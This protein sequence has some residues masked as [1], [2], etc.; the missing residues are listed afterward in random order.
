M[1]VVLY[2]LTLTLSLLAKS[3]SLTLSRSLLTDWIIRFSDTPEV[4]LILVSSAYI[5]G[6]ER[7]RE[8]GRS[9]TYR[10]KSR[11]PRIDPWGTPHVIFRGD[12]RCPC[13]QHNC[14][15]SVRYDLNHLQEG[16]PT[17][18][19]AS[20]FSNTLWSTVSN[21]LERSR[22]VTE[23][24]FFEYEFRARFLDLARKIARKP[25]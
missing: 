5:L 18:Y 4:D 23:F 1:K 21:A 22:K 19:S 13:T 20:F 2:L 7:W 17:P 12:E 24:D 6:V 25:F 3:Q 15:L 11:G 16:S 8:D 9:C 10:R 14:S